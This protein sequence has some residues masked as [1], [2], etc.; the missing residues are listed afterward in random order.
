MLKHA[1]ICKTAREI[2]MAQL[3]TSYSFDLESDQLALK[4]NEDYHLV[5]S[6]IAKFEAIRSKALSDLD[7]L[8]DIKKVALTN[9]S[10]FVQK[11]Q[12][13]PKSLNIPSRPK[14]PDVPVIDWSK[15]AYSGSDVTVAHGAR[16]TRNKK[17]PIPQEWIQKTSVKSAELGE[18]E[19]LVRGRL[20]DEQKPETF[21]QLWTTEEQ[22]KLEELLIEFPPERIEAV[23]I[24]K[25]LIDWEP[26]PC[27][28]LLVEFRSIYPIG[29][30]RGSPRIDTN[31]NISPVCV[32]IPTGIRTAVYMPEDNVADTVSSVNSSVDSESE[33]G[34]DSDLDLPHSV[35]ETAEYKELMALKSLRQ[36]KLGGSAEHYGYKCDGCGEEPIVGVRYHCVECPQESS[37]DFCGLCNSKTITFASHHPEHKMAVIKDAVGRNEYK[38]AAI[39]PEHTRPQPTKLMIKT[40][41]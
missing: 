23:A 14:I 39:I 25:L 31:S 29:S 3:D 26:K 7:K 1:E 28:R 8:H 36:V 17:V 4:G 22:R 15:Y 5:L 21:N 27:S 34:S 33:E 9:P 10:E 11:L 40:I 38:E 24:G 2:N 6:S 20:K 35:K 13:D 18:N 12:S 19:M 41:F 30:V 37:V 16:S 32:H